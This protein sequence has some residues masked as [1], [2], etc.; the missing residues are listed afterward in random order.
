MT[1]HNSESDALAPCPFCLG[2]EARMYP[3][4][5]DKRTPYNPADRAFPLVRCPCGAEKAGTDWD[6]TGR[7]A[8]SAWNRRAAPK[9]PAVPE[10]LTDAE[11]APSDGLE[12]IG[13]EYRW[14]DT[15]NTPNRW[16]A[17]E[18]CRARNVH[19]NTDKD[20]AEEIQAYIEMGNRYELRT[21][22]A[23]TQSAPP[24]GAPIAAQP[25]GDDGGRMG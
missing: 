21:L 24:A 4:T 14:L 11:K 8:I 23:R 16:S 15:A 7:T 18:R 25:S 10:T 12:V 9:A 5:C 1:S 22:Y 6:Q 20:F 17:W 3:P 2:L 19:M 13:W